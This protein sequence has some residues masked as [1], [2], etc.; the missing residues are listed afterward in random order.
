MFTIIS[1][2]DKLEPYY[3]ITP[4]KSVIIGVC[5]AIVICAIAVTLALWSP[6]AAS[7]K[8]RKAI[9]A[10]AAALAAA[11]NS[12]GGSPGPSIKSLGS[13]EIDGNES[14]EKNPDIIPDTMD[15]DDQVKAAPGEPCFWRR[16]F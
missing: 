9:A 16:V 14:D 3:S 11:Q 13:K 1:L 10:Q 15:S 7:R 5:A 8:R 6:C 4:T 12:D 2:A